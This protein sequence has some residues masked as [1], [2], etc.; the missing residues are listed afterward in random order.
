MS[1]NKCVLVN[2]NKCNGAFDFGGL[3]GCPY[4]H[5]C[6]IFIYIF[7]SSAS[8]SFLVGLL[9]TGHLWPIKKDIACLHCVD[10]FSSPSRKLNFCLFH[11]AELNGILLNCFW[12]T[13]KDYHF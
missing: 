11:L 4:F 10:V 5:T 2:N 3:N 9:C 13:C 12:Y 7:S 6:H 8:F 1:F